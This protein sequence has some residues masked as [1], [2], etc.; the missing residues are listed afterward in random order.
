M[1]RLGTTRLEPSSPREETC[2]AARLQSTVL[3]DPIR[4]GFAL[5]GTAFLMLVLGFGISTDVNNISFAVL[6]RDQSHE[7]RA[8]LEKLRGSTYF[9]E[10]APVA[11]TTISRNDS[12]MGTSGRPLKSR[13]DSATV[14]NADVRRGSARGSM[15]P[16]RFARPPSAAIWRQ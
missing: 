4:L 12:R 7:S 16:C 11:T 1:R 15:A 3:R 6:D 13:P 2:T 8:Y 9:V 10:K 5:F 14:S